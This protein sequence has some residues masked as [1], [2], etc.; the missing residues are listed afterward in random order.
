MSATRGGGHSKGQTMPYAVVRSWNG[1][2]PTRTPAWTLG[3]AE[4]NMRDSL[5]AAN[6][7][8]SELDIRVIDRATGGTV[9]T[10]QR[11]AVCGDRWATEYGS[12]RGADAPSLCDECDGEAEP[13]A[14]LEQGPLVAAL[15][16]RGLDPV[17]R[18]DGSVD[19]TANGLG[20]TL[21]PVPHA[22]TGKPC[23]VWSAI[24]PVGSR[25]WFVAASAAGF[26]AGRTTP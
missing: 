8:G 4:A 21:E 17:V 13:A 6:R 11:C 14:D 24:G 12:T 10:P 2:K 23:G 18:Q 25:G 22:V 15:R 20:W 26:I 19:V 5:R 9:I 1:G 16:S 7:R 3:A